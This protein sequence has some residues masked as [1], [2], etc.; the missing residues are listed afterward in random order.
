[1]RSE[2]WRLRL[3][4]RGDPP[5][6]T[7]DPANA[8]TI[9]GH[10]EDWAEK[11][12]FNEMSSSVVAL[13][14]LPFDDDDAPQQPHK[15]GQ[16][17]DD[18]D[19]ER[20]TAW[21]ARHERLTIGRDSVAAAVAIVAR[22]RSFHPV[23]EYLAGLRW[24]RTPR[25]DRW[26]TTYLDAEETIYSQHVGR[27]WLISAIA[28][29]MR[30][31]AKVDHVLILEGPQGLRKSQA[32]AALCGPDD[33]FT[34]HIGDLQSKDT[35]Q[36]IHGPWIIELAELDQFSR[37]EISRI[38]AFFTARV[39][40]FRP[41]YGRS[42]QN[43]PR[44]CVFAGTV[45]P[46]AIGYL[47]DD[48]GNRRF[49]PVKVSASRLEEIARDRDQLWA[50]ALEAYRDGARWYPIA[51]E[52]AIVG[53][54]KEQQEARYQGDEW[55]GLIASWI[56]SSDGRTTYRLNANRVDPDAGTDDELADAQGF[57]FGSDVMAGAL[58]LRPREMGRAE[59]TRV[60]S[61]LARIGLVAKRPRVDSNARPTVYGWPVN[62]PWSPIP[63]TLEAPTRTE[64]PE[65]VQRNTDESGDW[66]TGQPDNL[67]FET[68]F[69][70]PDDAEIFDRSL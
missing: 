55:E 12:A 45:N 36:Q 37:S 9:L 5:K 59:Q 28:R 26:L 6:P 44:Q 53:A 58:G 11:L 46:G 61:C 38:K 17:L 67:D 68:R 57:F 8:I 23:R 42:P 64:P 21:L 51:S 1:M 49:W 24:D 34:D 27:W 62:P 18:D 10:H 31:G 35:L 63:P 25:I 43:F 52:T 22:K 2:E 60:G 19:H 13:G 69:L 14:P 32:I 47:R 29:I 56:T 40:R 66:T 50:E 48:T 39:D 54:L 16:R 4:T 3:V 65:V 30:P 33:W 70:E 7:K 41:P 20:I 15:R